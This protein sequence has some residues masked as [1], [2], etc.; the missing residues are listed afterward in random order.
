MPRVPC[1][2]LRWPSRP[3]RNTQHASRKEYRLE[4]LALQGHLGPAHKSGERKAVRHQLVHRDAARGHQL[5]SEALVPWSKDGR[6]HQVPVTTGI[7]DSLSTEILDGPLNEGDRVIVGVELP[8]EQEERKLPPGFEL[9]PK[10][11]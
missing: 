5:Q 6:A 7:A 2:V 8:D 10:V 11:K 4:Y 3:L 1:F 9:G